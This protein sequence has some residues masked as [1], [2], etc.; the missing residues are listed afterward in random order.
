MAAK[1]ENVT[2]FGLRNEIMQGKFRPIYV[3][4]GEEPYFIDQLSDLIV[5]TALTEDE[6][7]FNLNIY[8]G[9]DTQVVD[10]INTCKQY[11]NFAQ[12]RVVVLREAQLLGKNNKKELDQFKF[13]ADNPLPSTILVVCSKGGALPARAFLDTL[14]NGNNGVVFT[15]SK[16]RAGRD[17]EGVIANYATSVGCRID[18]KSTTMLAD[19]IGNDL[20]RL[21]G[22]LDKLHIIVGDGADGITPEIIEKNIGISKD[23]N[24]WELE[25]ALSTRNAVKAYRIIDYFER[26][27]KN[28]PTMPT[29][30]SLFGFF[31][32]VL[33]VRATKDKSQ[34]SLMAATGAS[35]PFRL[36]KFE[37]A[38][39]NF[40]TRACVNII[41]YLRECD[42]KSKGI[43]SRQDP[44]DLL[45]ELVYKIL[46]S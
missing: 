27:P 39:A 11:P 45:R 30:S 9:S 12:R 4:Q 28:N 24:N 26:N 7:D 16:V 17:L 40:S 2:Y 41:T 14:R 18:H 22:E 37:K 15:S 35:S 20:S 43:G 3:L 10:V 8:Y 23:F 31:S 44:Y 29:V 21:F 34:A 19:F 33:I 1:K 36:S 6:K 25:D 38:A 32:S 46:H 13:Y 42:V 5:D